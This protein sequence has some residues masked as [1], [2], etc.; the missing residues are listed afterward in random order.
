MSFLRRAAAVSVLSVAVVVAGVGPSAYAA[1][2]P[3]VTADG[4]YGFGGRGERPLQ[5][6]PFEIPRNGH[7]GF[8]WGT[9]NR[10]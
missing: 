9:S 3:S 1:A 7:V 5:F 2:A 4:P 6:G 10:G 8:T